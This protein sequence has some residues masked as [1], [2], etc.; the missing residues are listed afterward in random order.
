MRKRFLGLSLAVGAVLASSA[1]M[2]MQPAFAGESSQCYASQFTINKTDADTGEALS[3][4]QFKV[5]LPSGV[6]A[7]AGD[8]ADKM[9]DFKTAFDAAAADFYGTPAGTAYAAAQQDELGT[10]FPGYPVDITGLTDPAVQTSAMAS[11]K[12]DGDGTIAAL[13]ADTQRR[14]DAINAAL[15]ANPTLQA[16]DPDTYDATI[17]EQ[18]KLTTVIAGINEALAATTWA[19][20]TAAY[21]KLADTSNWSYGLNRE[22]SVQYK[23]SVAGSDFA[24]MNASGATAIG[25]TETITVTTD[26]TGVATFTVFGM[27]DT[28]LDDGTRGDRSCSQL[29]ANLQEMV[30]PNGYT[31]NEQVRNEAIKS[32]TFNPEFPVT[33]GSV[34]ITNSKWNSPTPEPPTRTSTGI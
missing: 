19:D 24:A 7:L 12:A 10:V 17:A 11:W 34:T 29:T 20:F 6:Y 21:N 3:G 31:L 2:P 16:V 5:T 14:L 27:K 18:T 26:A 33:T 28:Y 30:A 9:P 25:A 1:I 4:A 15:A 32:G 13:K 23:D 8:H 22:P